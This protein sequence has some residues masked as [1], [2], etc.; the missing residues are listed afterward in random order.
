[1]NWQR[2]WALVIRY[3]LTWVS[4]I[5]HFLDD[6]F[7]PILD[8]ILWGMTSMWIQEGQTGIP[9]SVLILI[10]CLIFWYVVQR[11]N[12]AVFMNTFEELWE[13]NF[14][15]LF[16]TPLTV[17]EWMAAVV[18]L[19]IFR[20][21]YTL[22]ICLFTTWCLYKL[23]IFSAI[24]FML[25]PYMFSL[26]LSG[27]FIGFFSTSFVMYWGRK[28]LFFAWNISWLFA[29]FSSV[30]YPLDVLPVWGQKVAYCLPMT[31]AFQGMRTL[32]EHGTVAW[33]DLGISLGLNFLY[34]ILSMILFVVMFEESRKKGFAR[35]Q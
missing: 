21:M 26:L 8:L 2:I 22:G 14:I 4:S 33:Y 34:L 12:D 16:S 24:G 30:Y 29:P 27:L 23:N 19:S 17:Y 25:L 1:M 35:L 7:W 20:I 5:N 28:A 11:A 31:Y 15:N 18:L 3:L 10:T 32:I 9:K 13:R 6:A